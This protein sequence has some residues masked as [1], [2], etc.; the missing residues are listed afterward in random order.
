[1]N[2]CQ[3]G[4]SNNIQINQT[5]NNSS[6]SMEE[7]LK[8]KQQFEDQVDYQFIQRIIQEL[9]QSCALPL[10]IPAASIP[11]L[12]LQAAQWFWQNC[13]FCVEQRYFTVKNRDIC[14]QC[15][16]KIVTLPPQVLGV[17]GVYKVYPN[18]YFGQLG[19]F[20]LERMIVNNTVLASGAGTTVTDTFGNGSGYNL[21][22]M[23]AALYEIST[24]KTMFDVPVTYNYNEFSNKLVLLGDV[25]NSDLILQCW[26]RCKLQDL[27]KNYY[28]FRLCVCF[29][30]RSMST[31]MGAFTFKLPGGTEINYQVF[32]DMADA[33]IEKIEEWVKANHTP[34]YF[35]MSN[36]I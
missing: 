27:Y 18:Y 19:D 23:M 34:D 14:R 5:E 2:N 22:D 15:N 20:T 12:I 33:E 35:I 30:L 13:D 32:R 28:F 9:T 6:Q 7:Y 10:P 25:A 26:V 29:G 8:Q 1:M 11:P 16:N 36:T 21:T 4:V 17:D 3:T 31:I 24:F